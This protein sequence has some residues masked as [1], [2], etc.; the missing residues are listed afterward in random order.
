MWS[1][2][3][4]QPDQYMQLYRVSR[5]WDELTVTWNDANSLVAWTNPGGDYDAFIADVPLDANT[6]DHEFLD[7]P[8][9][10]TSTVQDWVRGKADDYGLLLI[11]DSLNETNLKSSNYSS[12]NSTRLTITYATGCPCDLPADLDYDCDV[13][14]EYNCNL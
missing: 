13:D 12:T 10:I 5:D 6:G 11:N 9:D 2:V 4:T 8:I 1:Q 7:P 14:C 3:I